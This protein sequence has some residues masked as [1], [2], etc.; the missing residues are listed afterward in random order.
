[1]PLQPAVVTCLLALF[2]APKFQAQTSTNKSE[3]LVSCPIILQAEPPPYGLARAVLVSLW[4]AKTAAGRGD[5][6]KA[7]NGNV[8]LCYYDDRNDGEGPKS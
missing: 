8:I 5:Q 4:Y 6:I 3:A 7:E 2:L 1:M